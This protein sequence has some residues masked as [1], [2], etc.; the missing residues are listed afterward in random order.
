MRC[1]CNKADLQAWAGYGEAGFG[2]KCGMSWL[3]AKYYHVFDGKG[4]F[5]LDDFKIKLKHSSAVL[6]THNC[7]QCA[8]QLKNKCVDCTSFSHCG[9]CDGLL[10]TQNQSVIFFEKYNLPNYDNRIINWVSE[11]PFLA[12]FFH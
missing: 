2:C 12:M 9:H 1:I 10:F 4:K 5:R 7:P 11:I 8:R 6:S 3:P